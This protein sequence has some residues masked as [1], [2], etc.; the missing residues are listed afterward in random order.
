MAPEP[1]TISDWETSTNVGAEAP[2]VPPVTP[3]A[4]PSAPAEPA[5]EAES[6]L[7]PEPEGARDGRGRYRQRAVSQRARPEDVP[8]INQLTKELR[9]L[10]AEIGITSQPGES[11]RVREL[12]MR[13]EMAKAARDS[14][15]PAAAV[16]QPPA[17]PRLTEPTVS[18]F[19]EPEPTIDQFSDKDDPYAAWTRA[20]AAYDRRKETFENQQR[21][22]VDGTQA[23]KTAHVE[24]F[25]RWMTEQEQAYQQR[26]T[27]HFTMHPDAKAAF[28]AALALPADQQ[29]TVTPFM[30]T[31]IKLHPRG[32]ELILD[33]V[34]HPDVA[35]AMALE[36]AAVAPFDA[37]GALNPLVASLQRRLL[38]RIS[39][40]K[41]GSSPARPVNVAPRPPNPVRTGPQPSGDSLPGDDSSLEA[42]EKAFYRGGRRRR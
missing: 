29:I 38:A 37:N 11:P 18:S 30:Q 31:A 34:A 20:L 25:N 27:T 7:E 33:L 16:V 39:D 42:H 3:R 32:P 15:K 24:A 28:D 1:A 21:A 17:P 13:V 19:T 4:E 23:A 6:P 2:V 8:V 12:R 10:E 9:E 35:D 22:A 5:L 41:T 14:R 36:T 26:I 40:V